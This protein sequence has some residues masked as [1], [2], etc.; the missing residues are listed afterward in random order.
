MSITFIN[1]AVVGTISAVL[2]RNGGKDYS[3]Y[4][5]DRS[6]GKS[7]LVDSYTGTRADCNKFRNAA[8]TVA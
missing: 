7:S 2:Y 8:L 5:Y 4:V 1:V 6:K 3:V